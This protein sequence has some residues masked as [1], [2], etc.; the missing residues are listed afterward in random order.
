MYHSAIDSNRHNWANRFDI[1]KKIASYTVDY[2]LKIHLPKL[3]SLK[4]FHDH[5]YT[6]SQDMYST[7]F[8]KWFDIHN[9]SGFKRCSVNSIKDP[10][11]PL[12][13]SRVLCF[14]T[15]LRIKGQPG[16]CI[17]NDMWIPLTPTIT[18]KNVAKCLEYF[19]INN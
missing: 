19:R 2:T 14:N 1:W 6:L 15:R 3:L 16:F 4:C 10:D 13:P 8:H 17:A 12:K 18:L 11:V 5:V 9:T 7:Y